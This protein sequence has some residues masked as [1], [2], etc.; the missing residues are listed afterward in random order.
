M[1]DQVVI[2]IVPA[3]KRLIG[4]YFFSGYGLV[5][6]QYDLYLLFS[7]SKIRDFDEHICALLRLICVIAKIFNLYYSTPST[8]ITPIIAPLILCIVIKSKVGFSPT[9]FSSYNVIFIKSEVLIFSTG[10]KDSKYFCSYSFF[11]VNKISFLFTSCT[12]T[13]LGSIE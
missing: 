12:R 5:K 6:K 13:K 9:Y 3:F 10:F 4:R 1:N 7:Y 11:I 8:D 2:N